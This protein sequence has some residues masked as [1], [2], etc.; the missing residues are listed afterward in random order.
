MRW[1]ELFTDLEAQLA[2]AE[3][4]ELAG[5]VSD[6]TRRET[7]LLAI[8]GRLG[9]AIGADLVLHCEGVQQLQGRLTEVGP[10]WLLLEEPGRA[11]ALVSARHLVDVTG[12]TAASEQ[13]QGKVWRALDLPW[14]L[15]SLARSRS[16]VQVLQCSGAAR[17]GTLDRVG[18]DFVELAEHPP[19]EARRRGAVSQVVLI[20]IEAISVVRSVS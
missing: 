16:A 7:S 11:E 4:A 20:A 18:A 19:G 17:S 14:A 5:E 1:D 15:R 8:T 10:D 2:Q 13:Q 9:A 12:L 3:A 6:R